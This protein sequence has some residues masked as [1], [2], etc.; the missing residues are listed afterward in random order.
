MEEAGERID[1]LEDRVIESNQ[2]EEMR[3]K[4]IITNDN[5]LRGLSDSIMCNNIHIIGIPE[6][7]EK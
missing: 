7:E 5:R 1:E 2:D 6:R 4:R 3:E